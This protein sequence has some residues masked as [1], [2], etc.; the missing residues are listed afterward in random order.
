MENVSLNNYIGDIFK[1]VHPPMHET[2]NIIFLEISLPNFKLSSSI[3]TVDTSNEAV[4]H[5]MYVRR[6]LQHLF[7]DFAMLLSPSDTFSSVA[8]IYRYIP[9]HM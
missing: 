6:Y 1:K 3:E 2:Q 5:K 7:T 8:C 4:I 9:G